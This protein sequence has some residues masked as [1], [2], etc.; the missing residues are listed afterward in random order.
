MPAFNCDPCFLK[1]GAMMRLSCGLRLGDELEMEGD[2]SRE[3]LGS[4][5]ITD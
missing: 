5:L 4:K 2:N 1:F 3:T